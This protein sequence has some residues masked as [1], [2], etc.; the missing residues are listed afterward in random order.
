MS[1]ILFSYRTAF[2][3]GTDHTPFQ[4]VYKL[5]MFLLTWYFLPSKPR[6]TYDPKHVRVLISHMLELEKL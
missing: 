4:L 3:V 2:K 1:T 5:H 6:Q